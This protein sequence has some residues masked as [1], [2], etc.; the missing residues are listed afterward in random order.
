L[1]YRN[2]LSLGLPARSG[3]GKGS[4]DGA[5]AHV[6]VGA[7]TGRRPPAGLRRGTAVMVR[8]RGDGA[9]DGR[10]WMALP[11]M[12]TACT[13]PGRER[14][15]PS[16]AGGSSAGQPVFVAHRT[17][18]VMMASAGTSEGSLVITSVSS[19]PRSSS[20]LPYVETF[21]APPFPTAQPR[22]KDGK[23]SAW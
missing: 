14:V 16:G 10:P 23:K 15:V 5:R 21:W 20:Q 11:T 9:V 3:D 6:V 12:G 2:P 13:G 7:G 18:R 17:A 1:A 4:R 19:N 8:Y 22:M